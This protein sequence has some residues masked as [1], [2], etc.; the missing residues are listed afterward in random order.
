MS[1]SERERLL[2]LAA[3]YVLEHGIADLTLRKLGQAIG[4]NNRMLLYYFGSKEQLIE[5]ALTAAAAGFP[6]LESAI[7]ALD[8]PGPLLDRL[9]ACWSGIA[10]A[11]NLPFHRLFFEVFGVAAHRPGRFDRF[12][13][14]VGH[15]WTNRV[16]TS[17]RAEGV[18]D[19]QA[20]RLARE[21]VAL[22]RGLQFDLL[23]TGD[24]AAVADSYTATAT[25]FAER[26]ATA[27]LVDQPTS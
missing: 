24:A 26:C 19:P 13:A 4:T 5:H 1:E 27:R 16:A 25:A 8:G 17:L 10:A 6:A 21:L 7:A 22:W 3:G 14:S 15:D 9:L 18:P 2:A 11:E 23:S 12:L 20:H